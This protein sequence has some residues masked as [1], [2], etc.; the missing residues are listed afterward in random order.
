MLNLHFINI[1]LFSRKHN[2]CHSMEFCALK[3]C[4]IVYLDRTYIKWYNTI[5]G[6]ESA[7]SDPRKWA[8]CCRRAHL[9]R[10]IFHIYIFLYLKGE[11]HNEIN[12]HCQK[13]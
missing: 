4:L 13:D 12:R 6:S 11:N 7:V 3:T 10:D 5:V 2:Y 8:F 9:A 1:R